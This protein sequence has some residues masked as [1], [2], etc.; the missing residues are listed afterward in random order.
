MTD[1]LSEN[2]AFEEEFESELF[3]FPD[4]ELFDDY[5]QTQDLPSDLESIGVVG[6]AFLILIVFAILNSFLAPSQESVEAV[7][8]SIA[9]VSAPPA[10]STPDPA[11]VVSPYDT[12]WVTQGLHGMS[13]GHMA[14]D[15]AAGKGAT[16]YS[17][18]HGE[19]TAVYTDQ[20]GNPTLVIENSRYAV[21]MLHGIYDVAMGQSIRAGDP[22][23]TESNL[24]YTT[25]MNGIPCINR[26][27]GYHTHLNMFDKQQQQ[28][29]N[30]LLLLP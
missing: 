30:P 28:N 4:E 7:E 1:F 23:G 24:G 6:L 25:D 11:L 17:P 10:P 9:P 26:D 16:I 27:C 3:E 2:H 8:I 15:I 14:I 13:Y 21:T 29:V 19:V 12:Y 18:I 20:Y 5:P 22:I